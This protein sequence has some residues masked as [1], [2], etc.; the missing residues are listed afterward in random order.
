ML[1]EHNKSMV[2]A[3]DAPNPTLKYLVIEYNI[4][5]ANLALGE[6]LTP[7]MK[8]PTVSPLEDSSWVAIKAMIRK[9]DSNFLMEE[10]SA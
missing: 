1:T 6:K 10:L 7:G 3:T 4:P 2:A 9:S 5:R 8:S